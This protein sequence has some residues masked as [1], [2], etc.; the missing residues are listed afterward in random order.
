MKTLDSILD[1]NDLEDFIKIVNGSLDKVDGNLSIVSID[2]V[3]S[4]VMAECMCT[5][6]VVK[7][8]CN[9]GHTSDG[10]VVESETGSVFFNHKSDLELTA[11]AVAGF[12]YI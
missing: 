12:L 7:I 6:D 8:H 10:F 4:G 3:Q 5:F 2:G 11:N 1:S 9:I